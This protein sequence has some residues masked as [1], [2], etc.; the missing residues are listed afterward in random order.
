MGSANDTSGLLFVLDSS[1][2]ANGASVPPAQ[3][4]V[5]PAVLDEFQPGGATRRRLDQFLAAGMQVRQPT[6]RARARVA[7]TVLGMGAAS[8]LSQADQEVAAL[9]VDVGPVGTLLTDDY[10]LQDAAKRLGIRVASVATAGIE[11]KKDWRPR[12]TGC[13]RWFSQMPKKDECPIC[14]SLVKAKPRP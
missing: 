5:P 1:A 6:D 2:I 8:R 10:T 14:G 3:A 4:M 13:G 7:E 12:C 11:A 9:A